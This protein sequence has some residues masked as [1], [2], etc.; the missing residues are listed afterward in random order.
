MEK[1]IPRPLPKR[2]GAISKNIDTKNNISCNW[3]NLLNSD[4]SIDELRSIEITIDPIKKED[5][6]DDI[7]KLKALGISFEYPED[8]PFPSTKEQRVNEGR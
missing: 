7:E 8:I 4:A 5:V 6:K 3:N 2:R 1:P